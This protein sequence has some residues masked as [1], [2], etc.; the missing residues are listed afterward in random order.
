MKHHWIDSSILQTSDKQHPT[1]TGIFEVLGKKTGLNTSEL[2]EL[3]IDWMCDKHTELSNCMAIALNQSKQTFTEWLQHIILNDDFIP[4]ELTIYCLS[5]F[6]NVHTLVYT[7]NFCWPTLINQFK[8]DD[9]ELYNKSDI[10]LVYVGHHMFAELKH[11]RQPKP[12]LMPATLTT[13][14]DTN[15]TRKR[16]A[17]GKHSKKITNRGDRPWSKQCRK[18]TTPPLLPLPPTPQPSRRSRQNIDYLQLND[19]LEEPAVTSS[20]NRK[21]KPYLPP[22]RAGPSASRQAAS[23]NKRNK[24]DLEQLMENTPDEGNKLPDLV[25]NRESSETFNAITND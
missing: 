19:G 6:L 9:D 5:R 12:S 11:I 3:L 1:T 15:K 24:L 13:P 18:L 22:P 2:K 14:P 17:S 16:T 25:V 21:R 20:K 7:S 10:R 4:D 8:Y 23:R